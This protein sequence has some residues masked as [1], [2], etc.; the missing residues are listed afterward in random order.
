MNTRQILFL[1]F[2]SSTAIETRLLPAVN[3]VPSDVATLW[4]SCD[5]RREPL[6]SRVVRG[7][8]RSGTV[9]RYVT[10]HVSTFKG[11]HARMAAFYAFPKGNT[12]LPGLLHLHG[13]G[14][15]AFQRE[16]LYYASR[17]YACLSIN[18]GGRDMEDAQTR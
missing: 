1:V 6:E 14:Q 13:G 5:P 7:W 16:V 2:L 12:N 11:Q 10:Y 9:C 3:E 17:G 8:E 4:T 18:W 15:R